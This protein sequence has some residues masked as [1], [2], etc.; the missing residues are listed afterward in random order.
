MRMIACIDFM[1][2]SMRDCGKIVFVNVT[3]VIQIRFVKC[4]G[5]HCGKTLRHQ[6]YMN[7]NHGYVIVSIKV[8]S[9]PFKNLFSIY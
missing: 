3:N 9:L 5:F 4:K 8:H 6:F 7:K 2:Y 1:V